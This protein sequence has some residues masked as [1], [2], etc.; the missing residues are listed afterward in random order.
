MAISKLTR[1]PY[2]VS[3]GND[4]IVWPSVLEERPGGVTVRLGT[5]DNYTWPF[6]YV[7]AGAII[8]QNTTTN[9]FA[10]LDVVS[11]PQGTVTAYAALP[12]GWV[13]EGLVRATQDVVKPING[14][15]Y[16]ATANVSSV[17]AGTAN[18]AAMI[19][20]IETAMQTAIS[21]ALPKMTFKKN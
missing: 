2:D 17:Y 12:D 18:Y 9:E 11:D 14:A 8:L 21:T 4:D 19:I 3:F 6:T 20:P 5:A 13:Y 15:S 16:T 1:D 10:I 7:P